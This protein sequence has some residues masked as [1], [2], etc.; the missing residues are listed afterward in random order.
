MT[1]E[2][3]DDRP[4]YTQ[5]LEQIQRMI[6]SGKYKPGDRLPTVRD[7]AA[8]AAVNPNTVQRALTEL[9]RIG[10]V[11]SQRT[12]GR[13]ITDDE[14]KIAEI[15]EKMAEDLIKEFYSNMKELGYSKKE[16]IELL[17]KY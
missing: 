3:K 4:I 1:W 13:M 17:E 5:L 11:Y 10:L 9:E 7:L 2:F 6:I 16:I 12:S 14:S 15:K 8:E